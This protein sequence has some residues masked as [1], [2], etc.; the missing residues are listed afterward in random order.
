MKENEYKVLQDNNGNW[1]W[2]TLDKVNMFNTWQER[3]E[4]KEYMDEPDT[5]DNFEKFY[6]AYATGGD[7]DV[8]PDAFMDVADVSG[9]VQ[10]ITFSPTMRLR[11]VERDV[12]EVNTLGKVRLP[13]RKVRILQQCFSG[14]DGT[15][16]WEDIKLEVE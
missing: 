15:Y 10:G 14:S 2:I 3:M 9:G 11:F 6:G 13:A 8:I 5:F 7:R 12:P 1:Y 16:V 4:G